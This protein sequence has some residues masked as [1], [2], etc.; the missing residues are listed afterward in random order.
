VE[1][2]PR[3]KEEFPMKAIAIVLA[4]SGLMAIHARAD[5]LTES[6]QQVLKEQ[7]F[8]YGDINGKRDADTT[9]AIRRYQ[10][11]NG[12]KITGD[13]N[14]ETQ[15]SLGTKDGTKEPAPT[16]APLRSVPPPKTPD[17][18]SDEPGE[19][20]P[21]IPSPPPRVPDY[22]PGP[23]R[24]AR[25]PRNFFAG[26]PYETA[27]PEV[28]ERVIVGAQSQLARQGY[29]REAIDG[30]DGP[31][32]EFALRAYQT[33]FG[34]PPSGR[35]DRETL[36]ALGLLPGQRGPGITAPRRSILRW[37]RIFA[38]RGERVYTPPGY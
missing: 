35:L 16:S 17:Q 27:S 31:G 13:L 10:I 12:L 22:P 11:R 15:R 23:Q 18:P 20:P 36:G 4:V 8:Y 28:Q 5:S 26:T 38:P 33:E 21:Q 32:T 30:L 9:A 2:E 29:Y 1:I 34:I 37:P 3:P 19:Q 14:P 24:F 7:G 25:D 6:A